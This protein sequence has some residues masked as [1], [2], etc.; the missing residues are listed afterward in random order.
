VGSNIS[1]HGVNVDRKSRTTY[2]GKVFF[3]E[4]AEAFFY[5]ESVEG[6]IFSYINSAS[7][8]AALCFLF[9]I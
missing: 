4:A 9:G 2:E 7:Y 8:E 5:T 1:L 3:S 6:S